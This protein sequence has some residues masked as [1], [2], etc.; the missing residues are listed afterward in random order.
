MRR[1]LKQRVVGSRGAHP[2]EQ[3]QCFLRLIPVQG[4]TAE[5]GEGIGFVRARCQHRPSQTLRVV[6]A[7]SIQ[8]LSRAPPSSESS[9]TSQSGRMPVYLDHGTIVAWPKEI[10]GSRSTFNVEIADRPCPSKP[11]RQGS[12]P[13]RRSVSIIP[14][15]HTR[16]VIGWAL[17]RAVRTGRNADVSRLRRCRPC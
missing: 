2:L 15:A 5:H 17:R 12:E 11:G 9:N 10:G 6:E 8:G 3:A 13:I 14:F 16:A 1:E 4:N 7:A